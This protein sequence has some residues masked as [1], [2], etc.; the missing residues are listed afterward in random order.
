MNNTITAAPAFAGS[1]HAKK[2]SLA[3]KVGLLTAAPLALALATAQPV[4]ADSC[5]WYNNYDGSQ[6]GYCVGPRG[7]YSVHS[8]PP[9][10]FRDPPVVYFNAPP[11]PCTCVEEEGPPVYVQPRT[12]II[13]RDRPYTHHYPGIGWR[14]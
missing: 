6:D 7:G 1:H 12:I 11:P 10:V 9:V 2:A 5:S 4:K 14:D 13:E 3:T 8:D